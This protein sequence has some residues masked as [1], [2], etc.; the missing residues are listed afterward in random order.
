MS[1]TKLG[2]PKRVLLRSAITAAISVAGAGMVFGAVSA[3][4]AEIKIG[5][6]WG[7]TGPVSKFIPPLKDAADLA[8]KQ[9][10]EQGGLL[11]G[12]TLAMVLADTKCD[13]KTS[14]AA[15]NKLVNINNVVA[16]NGALCSGATIAAANT[17][18][19]PGGVV[20]ISPASTAP[21]ISNLKDKDLVFRVVPPDDFQGKILARVIKKRG[22]GSIAIT[23]IQN[24]Y[25]KGLAEALKKSFEALG[26][27]VAG[28]AAHEAKKASYRS[29]LATLKKGGAKHLVVIAYAADSGP[30]IMRQSLERGYFRKFIGVDGIN[31][32]GMLAKIGWQNVQGMIITNGGSIPG[33]DGEK[34]YNAAMKAYKPDS[35]GKPFAAN[36]YDAAFLLAL[37]IE[38]AGSADRSK[39]G[40]ALRKIAGPGGM[41]I[42]PGQWAKAKAAIAA[43]QKINYQGA[44]GP[45]DFDKAGDVAGVIDVFEVRGKKRVLVE[46]I[47]K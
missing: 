24:D 39:I 30:V 36:S 18:G 34:A 23:Y 20:M 17:V 41:V 40:P 19:I 35:I 11:K 4:S 8:I 21:A 7:V 42:L 43:G 26:G 29:E 9:V 27:K 28:Y 1:G 33:T 44:A 12:D 5:G 38:Q 22:I 37:A 10:N 46:K 14:S 13:G 16:I 47:A 31:E 6:L 15:A 45:H 3:Q 32:D 25:G 2:T